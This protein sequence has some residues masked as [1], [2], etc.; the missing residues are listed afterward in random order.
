MSEPAYSGA[1]ARYYDRLNADADYDKPAAYILQQLADAGIQ[2]GIV[3]DLG[4]GTGELSLR[5]AR[6]GYELL[7]VDAS[8]DMLS[9][10]AEKAQHLPAA[11]P[12]PLLLCQPL[13]QLDLF[14]T[15]RAAVSTFDTLNHL[16][17]KELEQAVRRIALFLEPGGLFIFDVNTPYKHTEIL[18][19]K[20]FSAK[21]K[22]VY[23]R[24]HAKVAD[25]HSLLI[26]MEVVPEN[27]AAFAVGFPEYTHT[28]TALERLL[29]D[30]GLH[31]VH[32]VD[33][34]QFC[35]PQTTSQR[36]FFTARK[37]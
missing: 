25:A 18:L 35:S 21:A 4:C 1:F 30:H 24:W 14:G 26:H 13:Q 7:C 6:Q 2:D 20:T 27:G 33:G 16:S 3:A 31:M 28:Q 23:C 37:E 32:R 29:R 12:Q 17:P 22:G 8:P 5:L 11:A 34:E 15:V 19:G 36:W 10:L 9:L